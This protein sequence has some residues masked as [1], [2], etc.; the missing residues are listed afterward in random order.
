MTAV[1]LT[2]GQML[3]DNNRKASYVKSI[4]YFRI[5]NIYIYIYIKKVYVY[6]KRYMYI[7]VCMHIY[8]YMHVYAYAMKK[9]INKRAM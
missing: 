9:K 6:I 4:K 5:I 1:K 2:V 3:L 7:Y 8:M